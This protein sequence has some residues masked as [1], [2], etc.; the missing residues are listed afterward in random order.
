MSGLTVFQFNVGVRRVLRER[1]ITSIEFYA[2]LHLFLH[3]VF[4]ELEH[5]LEL[6]PDVKVLNRGDM[7]R[8][9]FRAFAELEPPP[10]LSLKKRGGPVGGY[11]R[12][13]SPPEL[14]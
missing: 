8:L 2:P 10:S 7:H 4:K 3:Q 14:E 9:L 5:D 6:R 1:G 13:W 12:A 11:R